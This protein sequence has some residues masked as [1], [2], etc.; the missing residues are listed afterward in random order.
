MLAQI[1]GAMKARMEDMGI[2]LKSFLFSLWMT[3]LCGVAFGAGPVETSIFAVQGVE[4]DVTDTDADTAKN[5]ALIEA[6]VKAFGLLA[7]RLGNS[8]IHRLQF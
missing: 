5:K 6:Q 2:T 8:S 1:A 7:E 3:M 4:V